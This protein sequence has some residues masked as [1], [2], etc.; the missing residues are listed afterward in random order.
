MSN[1]TRTWEA[2]IFFLATLA[3]LSVVAPEGGLQAEHVAGGLAVL[4]CYGLVRSCLA[5]RA[6]ISRVDRVQRYVRAGELEKALTELRV[7]VAENESVGGTKHPITMYWRHALAQTKGE[8]GHADALNTA[9]VNLT[10]R[11]ETLGAGHRDT[12]A[13]QRLCDDLLAKI[14]R[15]SASPSSPTARR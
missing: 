4:V 12:L 3:V 13:S 2:I 1:R 6:A 8:L 5:R 9:K 15:S 10:Y 7:I 14:Q 11:T